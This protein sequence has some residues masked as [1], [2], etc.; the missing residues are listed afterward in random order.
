[1]IVKKYWNS[2]I[3]LLLCTL[4]TLIAPAPVSA[5]IKE[6]IAEGNYSM[7]DGETPLVGEE[8]A[9][10]DAKRTAI[11]QAGTYVESYSETKNYRLTADEIKVIASGVMEVMVLDKQR[12]LEGNFISFH[13]KIRATITTDKI[14]YLASRITEETLTEKYKQLQQDYGTVQQE[15]ANIKLQSGTFYQETPQNEIKGSL[16]SHESSLKANDWFEFGQVYEKTGEVKRAIF[17]YQQFIEYATPN[18]YSRIIIVRQRLKILL[19]SLAKVDHGFVTFNKSSGSNNINTTTTTSVASVATTSA[20]S[21][22]NSITSTSV[23][24]A[25]SA[26]SGLSSSS[27]SSRSSGSSG[28]SGSSSGSSHSSSGSSSGGGHSSGHGGR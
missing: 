6:I 17:A 18:D 10:L 28:S 25:K 11:E 9:L 19:E 1:L 15:L 12:N 3:S 27:S 21:T 16:F 26:S 8:R 23:S 4:F 14:E 2:I 20:V 24:S 5:A 13:T 22:V 7:G